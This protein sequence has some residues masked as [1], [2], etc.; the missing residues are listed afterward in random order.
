MQI[1]VII[2]FHNGH[3]H[4]IRC[5]RSILESSMSDIEVIVVDDNSAETSNKLVTIVKKSSNIY[6]YKKNKHVGISACRNWGVKKAKGKYLFFIDADRTV[7]KDTLK[8]V[9]KSMRADPAIGIV[10]TLLLKHNKNIE[11]AGHYFSMFGMPYNSVDLSNND[12]TYVFGARGAFA[13]RHKVFKKVKGYDND[14][15]FN[16][17]DTDLSWRTWLAGYAV[18]CSSSAKT[19]HHKEKEEES[20]KRM[21]YRIYFSGSKTLVSMILKNTPILTT[22]WLL[23]VCVG[24]WLLVSLKVLMTGSPQKAIWI[25]KGFWWNIA[26]IHH[27]LSKRRRIQRSAHDVPKEVIYGSIST[28]ELLKRGF[29]WGVSV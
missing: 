16:G 27:T 26:H 2:T 8:N 10:Q 24:T 12:L 9:L 6:Y 29:G 13:M 18:A 1:S 17:E 7:E 20:T 23:P 4:V 11:S 19:H 22:V 21:F 5:I 3:K 28:V 15:Q 25:Y 14:H